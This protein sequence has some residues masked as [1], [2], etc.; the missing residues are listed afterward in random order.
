MKLKHASYSALNLFEQCPRRY[1]IERVDKHKSPDSKPLRVGSAV[2]AGIAA[3]IRHLQAE[4]LQTDI[5]WSDWAIEA[6]AAVMKKEHR[7]L[8]ADEWEEVGAIFQT[9]ISSHLFNPA[10]IA[11]VEKREEIPL[12]DLTFW[13]V[14]DLLEVEDGQA[15]VRDWKTNWNVMSKAEVEKDF[16]LRCYAWAVH[17]LYGYDEV[18]CTLEFV[19]HG[20]FRTAF[21]GPDEIVLTEA[22]IKVAIESIEAETEWAPTPG[23][24]CSYCPWSGECPVGGDES[25]DPEALAGLILVLETR[26]KEAQA[27][28]KTYCNEHGPVMVG[29]EVFG[30]LPPKDGGWQVANKAAFADVLVSH[31]LPPWD[32]FNVSSTKLK[33]IRTAK[34]WA[35]VMADVEPLLEKDIS[36]KFGHRKAE[37]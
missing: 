13:A 2:H 19:R 29:G 21:I 26:I 7:I 23:S 35:H 36:T 25:E 5:T 37:G 31:G 4:N 14:I 32:Y 10:Q 9:F 11:E 1:K 27:K 18:E 34:K 16:Q 28:L 3:Y 33:S 8:D 22:R 12:G 17:K 24:H 6:A 20:A 30:Y 15:R